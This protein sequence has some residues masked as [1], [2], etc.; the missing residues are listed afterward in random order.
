[1]AENKK[2]KIVIFNMSSYLDWEKGISNRNW[3]ILRHLLL[4]ERVEKIIAVDYLPHSLKRTV[5][6]FYQMIFGYRAKKRIFKT[7]FSRI[8]EISDRLI[9]YSSILPK[10]SKSK[11]YQ[12]LNKLLVKLDFTDYLVWSYYP[13]EVGYFSKLKPILKIFDT[14]DNWSLHPSYKNF[15][16][17]LKDNYR[18]IDEQADV[19]LTV[20]DELK[21][22]F[23]HQEKVHF[24][25]NGVELKHYQKEYQIINRDIGDLKHPLIGYVGTIQ[26][27]LDLDLLEFLAKTNPEKSF[28]LIG[29]V[30]YKSIKEHF[31]K[32]PNIYFLGR[33]SYEELPMYLE[34]FD[35]GVV[36]HKV[37]NFI[38]TTNPM[39]IYEYLACGKPVVSTQSSGIGSL[40]EFV[41]LANNYQEFNKLIDKALK[42]D[43]PKLK[44]LRMAAVS[45]QSWLK[46][47]ER[48]L[49]IIY[50][51]I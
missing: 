5:K 44:E 14:V 16:D 51:K 15:Q 38:K 13:L 19:I 33:K 41:Y 7:P 36:P 29:P 24:L 46:R 3:H 9:V 11:F 8:L 50:Q 25:P 39:K 32:Y 30:W 37:D 40:D 12:E 49:E 45:E 43:R 35:V 42:E 10:I 26:D 6:T 18:A 1:M 4:D 31:L 21:S 17:K 27:R 34:Q 2:I 28:V 23:H 20:A 48:M 22:L 47:V